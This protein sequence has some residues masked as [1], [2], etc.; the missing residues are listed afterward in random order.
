MPSH[1]SAVKNDSFSIHMSS[2][3]LWA[4]LHHNTMQKLV[5]AN[6]VSLHLLY[7]GIL[8]KLL[9][10]MITLWNKVINNGPVTQSCH[11]ILNTLPISQYK[12]D[13]L[14]CRP[15]GDMH[16][17]CTCW[18]SIRFH[19]RQR[20]ALNCYRGCCC[21][22]AQHKALA[23]CF[24]QWQ[25]DD[26]QYGLFH[27]IQR[28]LRVG[29]W[30][31]PIKI[32]LVSS[33]RGLVWLLSL[34][35]SSYELSKTVRGTRWRQV[36]FAVLFTRKKIQ[37][38]SSVTGYLTSVSSCLNSLI[39]SA[40]SSGVILYIYIYLERRK[41]RSEMGPQFLYRFNLNLSLHPDYLILLVCIIHVYPGGVF[42]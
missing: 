40:C 6:M 15:C 35:C 36:S 25:Q 14:L 22:H 9:C 18:F 29:L 20:E 5:A 39:F 27:A 42:P 31:W 2:S 28:S 1:A 24:L 4:I 12:W 23:I 19:W 41:E 16:R 32:Q 3:S 37:L 7:F 10:T 34:Q 26:H 11:F 8:G 13:I 17:P 30:H 33:K 21:S 38:A